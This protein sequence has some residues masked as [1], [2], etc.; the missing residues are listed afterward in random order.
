VRVIEEEV[1]DPQLCLLHCILQYPTDL[2][3]ANLGM[4]EHLTDIYPEYMIGY[5]DHVPPD[6]GMITLLNSVIRGADIIEKHFTLDKSLEGNDHYHAMDPSDVRTFRE[7]TA[8][9][10]T[11]T[12]SSR[13]EPIAAESNSRKHARRSIVAIRDME[14]GEQ[15]TRKYVGIKR[16]GTGISPTMLDVVV[17]REA[18][19]KIPIDTIL[20]WDLV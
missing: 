5:S 6:S 20:S 16:P 15:I 11:T 12:G 4:I 10:M 19:K 1:S 18:K 14:R 17:G 7:N 2:E 13:K 9:L 3:N 8:R